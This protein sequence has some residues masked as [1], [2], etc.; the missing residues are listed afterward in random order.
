MSD[1]IL[2]TFLLIGAAKAG[3]TALA[4]FLRQHPDVCFSRPKET[5][6]F[7]RKY[8]HSIEWFSSHFEHYDG[9]SAIGEGSAGMLACT[10][11]P[12]RISD[13]I[14]DCDLICILRNPTDRALSHY[15]FYMYTGKRDDIRPFGELIRD[16]KSKFGR[17]IIDN[18][19]YI[20]HI[21]RYEDFLS[22]DQIEVV[23]HRSLRERP[24][25]LLQHLYSVIGVSPSFKPEV[26]TQHNVTKYP[27]SRGVYAILRS[28]WKAVD[29][30]L[31]RWVPSLADF[32]RNQGR[33][34]F[35]SSE[36][37][38]M[39]E[40]DRAYLHDLY[41]PYNRELEEWLGKDLSHWK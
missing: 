38:S 7:N 21:K 26:R 14:P 9:E 3:T 32:I 27:V 39:A 8:D 29:H 12:S 19:K 20:K 22:K 1:R 28:G 23:L 34:W 35:F 11:A 2:P 5:F 4:S 36:K 41:A 10:E 6:F 15:Y 13:T 17:E 37:P 31:D 40:E 24:Q 18:G 25:D 16:S 30:Y 33:K